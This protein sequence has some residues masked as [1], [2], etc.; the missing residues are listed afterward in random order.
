MEWVFV[1]ILTHGLYLRIR[2]QTRVVVVRPLGRQSPQQFV[3]T[4]KKKKSHRRP[5]RMNLVFDEGRQHRGHRA[6]HPE[7]V[8]TILRHRLDVTNPPV[9]FEIQGD[10]ENA[11]SLRLYWQ[12]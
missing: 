1:L 12:V 8:L 7:Q 11:G 4:V 9:Q 5:G 3:S 2:R 10:D 6:A